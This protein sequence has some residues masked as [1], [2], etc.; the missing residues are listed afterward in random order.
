MI[1]TQVTPSEISTERNDTKKERDISK[2]SYYEIG[3]EKNKEADR[4]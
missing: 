1:G 3:P 4:E 2:C